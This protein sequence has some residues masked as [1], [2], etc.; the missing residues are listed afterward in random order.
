M[1]GQEP[2]SP[3][4]ITRR[5]RDQVAACLLVAGIAGFLTAAWMWHWLAGLAATSVLVGVAGVA[6]GM[7]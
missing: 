4:K 6:T 7:E 2:S 1:A 3:R 5:A